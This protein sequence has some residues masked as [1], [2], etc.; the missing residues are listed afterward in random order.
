[1]F[2]QSIVTARAANK[3]WTLGI[4]ILAQTFLI[5][6]AVILPLIYTNGL[7]AL[8]SW[9][10]GIVTLPAPERVKAPP[11]QTSH[12]SNQ[13]LAPHDPRVFVAPSRTPNKVSLDPDPVEPGD[14]I[15]GAVSEPS[16]VGNPIGNF[17]PH[18][19]AIPKPHDPP[20]THEPAKP[21]V[22]TNAPHP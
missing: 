17:L 13:S 4:S 9:L 12:A 2:E 21:H 14:P 20:P 15:I 6:S 1:M 10:Q 19:M 22:E 18:T 5:S 16:N 8:S 7:P 11:P 3:T